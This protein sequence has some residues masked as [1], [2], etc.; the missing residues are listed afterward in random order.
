MALDTFPDLSHVVARSPRLDARWQRLMQSVGHMAR[1]FTVA[2]RLERAVEATLE[3]A[4]ARLAAIA[5]YR[6]DGTID[7]LVCSST[8]P[9]DLAEVRSRISGDA[10]SSTQPGSEPV[11]ELPVHSEK[12]ELLG[13]LWAFGRSDSSAREFSPDDRLLAE[14]LADTAGVAVACATAHEQAHYRGNWLDAMATISLELM[15]RD[16]QPVRVAQH[17]AE[18]VQRLTGARTVTVEVPD[19]DDPAQLEV[20]VAAGAGADQLIGTTFAR[21]GTLED[22]AMGT[23]EGQQSRDGTR[24]SAHRAPDIGEVLAAPLQGGPTGS[25]GVIVASRGAGQPGFRRSDLVMLED[26]A[27]QVVRTLETSNLR[28]AEEQLKLVEERDRIAKALQDNVIQRLFALGL[29]LQHL[30]R[31]RLQL[32]EIDELLSDLDES[33]RQIRTALTM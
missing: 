16:Y 8:D 18:L 13:R 32:G 33:I 25:R 7:H 5:L 19:P 22:E 2:G 9:A 4:G 6:E 1:D 31:S 17:I 28:R 21:A 24:P 10:G 26:F 11:L 20:R 27:R 12:G 30:N 29:Q 3:T 23:G 14:N 15:E